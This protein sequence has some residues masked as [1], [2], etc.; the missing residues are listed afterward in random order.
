[1][2]HLSVT[3]GLTKPVSCAEVFVIKVV[4]KMNSNN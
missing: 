2:S 1:M 3:G 4:E